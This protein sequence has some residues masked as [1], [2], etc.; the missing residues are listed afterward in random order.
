MTA[1]RGLRQL[2]T[3]VAPPFPTAN[4]T[5]VEDGKITGIRVTFDPRPLPPADE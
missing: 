4:R 1:S 5:H 2:R 3:T